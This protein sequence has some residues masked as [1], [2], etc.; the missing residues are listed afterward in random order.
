MSK[1]GN[2]IIGINEIATELG[3][4]PRTVRRYHAQGK[5]RSF[6]VGGATSPIKMRRV[7]LRKAAKGHKP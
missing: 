6:K 1:D 5:I 2:K 4:S 3:C 7:D